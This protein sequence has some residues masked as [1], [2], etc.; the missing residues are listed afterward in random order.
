M[1]GGK[2]GVGVT[3][4]RGGGRAAVFSGEGGG[5]AAEAVPRDVNGI[6]AR[7]CS[8]IRQNRFD[9]GAITE[10]VGSRNDPAVRKVSGQIH[11]AADGARGGTRL[12]LRTTRH[13][14][15]QW[16]LQSE[17]D[18]RARRKI[19]PADGDGRSTC[20][21]PLSRQDRWRASERRCGKRE[22]AR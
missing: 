10:A 16:S 12:H 5:V 1:G 18:L 13:V 8:R 21:R 7:R 20:A 9:T 17:A 11:S 14:C 15:R 3:F 2:G 22:H 6:A 4:W 19:C